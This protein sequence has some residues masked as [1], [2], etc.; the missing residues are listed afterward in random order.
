MT[1]MVTSEDSLLLKASEDG[2]LLK[3]KALNHIQKVLV[4]NKRISLGKLFQRVGV[5]LSSKQFDGLVRVLVDSGYC[6]IAAGDRSDS[7]YIVLNGGADDIPEAP[8]E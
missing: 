7:I 4:K 2:L 5:G 6:T 3:A 1:N 8:G